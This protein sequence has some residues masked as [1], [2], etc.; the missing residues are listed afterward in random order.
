MGGRVG[1]WAG[2]ALKCRKHFPNNS[3]TLAM[4]KENR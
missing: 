3:H 1:E 2:A 4:T